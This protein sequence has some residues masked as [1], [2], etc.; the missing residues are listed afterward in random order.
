[1]RTFSSRIAGVSL[2]RLDWKHHRRVMFLGFLRDGHK[3]NLITRCNFNFSGQRD[4]IRFVF[5][6][7]LGKWLNFKF[8]SDLTFKESVI[9]QP[10]FLQKHEKRSSVG[11]IVSLEIGI[12]QFEGFLGCIRWSTGINEITQPSVFASVINQWYFP[13]SRKRIWDWRKPL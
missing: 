11:C 13:Q 8:S 4:K 5:L 6:F 2:V 3:L 9:S 1:M 10:F 12:K 7:V